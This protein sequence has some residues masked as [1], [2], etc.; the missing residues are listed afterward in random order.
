MRE[1]EQTSMAA[2]A[3]VW[4]FGARMVRAEELLGSIPFPKLKRGLF[5]TPGMLQRGVHHTYSMFNFVGLVPQTPL[6][7]FLCTFG[8]SIYP[9]QFCL[10]S[11]FS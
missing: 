1:N 4:H 11:S 3:L 10:F 9:T 6:T 5:Q 2:G 8:L 7:C